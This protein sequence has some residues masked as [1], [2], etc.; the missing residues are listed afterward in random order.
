[1]ERRTQSS[2]NECERCVFKSHF[3]RAA[4]RERDELEV[5]ANRQLC[6]MNFGERSSNETGNGSLF[7]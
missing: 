3:I 5:E 4:A 2:R 1:M 6:T 7:R